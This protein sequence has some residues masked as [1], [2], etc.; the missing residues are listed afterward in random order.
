MKP[1]NGFQRSIKRQRIQADIEAFLEK[2]G[3]IRQFGPHV[4]GGKRK[5]GYNN[6]VKGKSS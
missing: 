3:K 4:Y 1:N 2:G 5:Y 6:T